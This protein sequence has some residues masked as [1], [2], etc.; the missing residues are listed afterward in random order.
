MVVV[1]T[2]QDLRDGTCGELLPVCEGAAPEAAVLAL[3]H[4]RSH[5]PCSN[6][7]ISRVQGVLRLL[8]CCSPALSS[9]S[10]MLMAWMLYASAVA[11]R[12][13]RQP[14]RSRTSQMSSCRCGRL[15]AYRKLSGYANASQPNSRVAIQT[16][17][18]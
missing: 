6:V 13:S 16:G 2:A 7:A 4:R 17:D 9:C 18:S 14:F 11:C 1:T 8:E 10:M 15:Q 12:S 3:L 5:V